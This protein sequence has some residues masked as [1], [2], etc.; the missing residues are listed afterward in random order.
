MSKA[1]HS[2]GVGLLGGLS[3]KE[4]IN[5][6]TPSSWVDLGDVGIDVYNC[7]CTYTFYRYNCKSMYAIA[8]TGIY[9]LKIMIKNQKQ[10]IK[11]RG[12]VENKYILENTLIRRK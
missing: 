7:V 6:E 2:D 12:L 11:V 10:L 8:N 9:V 5:M 3:W 4:V 1:R